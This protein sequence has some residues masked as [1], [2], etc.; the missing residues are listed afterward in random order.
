[1]KDYKLSST[2]LALALCI[3]GSEIYIATLMNSESY[4]KG[5]HTILIVPALIWI[6]FTGALMSIRHYKGMQNTIPKRWSGLWVF[7]TLSLVTPLGFAVSD[8]NADLNGDARVNS[9]DIS[10]LSACFGQSPINDSAC[11]HADVDEDGDIDREDFIFVS[12]RLGETYAGS[13]YP[14]PKYNIG[15]SLWHRSLGDMNGD[16]WLDVVVGSSDEILVLPNRGNGILQTQQRFAVDSGQKSLKFGDMNRDG[17]LDIVLVNST[18]AEVSVLLGTGDG[19]SQEQHRSTVDGNPSL[20]GLGDVNGDGWLDVVLNNGVLL[21]SGNGDFYDRQPF[22]DDTDVYVELGAPILGDVNGDDMLDVLS[23]SEDNNIKV[24]LNNGNG[25]MQFLHTVVLDNSPRSVALG[26]INQDDKLD[27][28]ITLRNSYDIFTLLGNGDGSFQ[29]PFRIGSGDNP[30]SIALGDI[31]LD[32]KLDVV[33][34]DDVGYNVLLGNGDGSFLHQQ[35]FADCGTFSGNVILDDVN[36]DG[37][38][39]AV[40]VCTDS[41]D[42]AYWGEQIYNNSFL[43]MLGNGD[44]SFTEQQRFDFRARGAED[45]PVQLLLGDS[46]GDSKPDV[47]EI[48]GQQSSNISVQL[49]RSHKN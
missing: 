42:R 40:A 19:G 31:N 21:N 24:L 27:I 17:W 15:D 7:L 49:N 30:S 37:I 25:N 32:N 26:D 12:A 18:S 10:K 2:L 11:S 20:I 48:G 4:T 3:L 39:D 44:G 29:E 41:V 5:I 38:L 43:L 36:G 14:T 45:L 33:F 34:I 9:L 1:M 22:F 13:I 47:I 16:G 28:V 6:F 8:S 46:N 23:M 35:N